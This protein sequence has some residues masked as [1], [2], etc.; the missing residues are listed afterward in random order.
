MKNTIVDGL[1]SKFIKD[2]VINLEDSGT[3]KLKKWFVEIDHF[4]YIDKRFQDRLI[5]WRN[6][7]YSDMSDYRVNGT[8]PESI[9]NS[10]MCNFNNYHEQIYRESYFSNLS[11]A[12]YINIIDLLINYLYNIIRENKVELII[13]QEAPHGAYSKILYDIAKAM[14][15]RTLILFSCFGI[16]KTAYCW[17]LDDIGYF[18]LNSHIGCSDKIPLKMSSEKNHDYC[19]NVKVKKY[20][21]ILDYIYRHI[22]KDVSNYFYKQNAI[23]YRKKYFK[24]NF[25]KSLKYVYFPLHL[26]PEM[27]TATLGGIYSNQLLAIERLSKIIPEEWVIYVKEHPWQKDY[28]W[29]GKYFY[30]RLSRISKVRCINKNISSEEMINNAQFVSTVTGTAGYEAI[31]KG[32]PALVFGKVWYRDLPGVSIY[33]DDLKNTDIIKHFSITDLEFSMKK[34]S[35]NF[36][37]GIVNGDFLKHCNG[38]NRMQNICLVSGFLKEVI[39]KET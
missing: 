20:D 10:L 22:L 3:I 28:R 29:R 4:D 36:L 8:C 16:N 5:H 14:N 12:D 7:L 23:K 19:R 2:V 34:L 35:K 6:V 32:V 15:I 21:G 17:D 25:D 39:I 33:N 27:T 30:E 38:F 26:Q 31:C 13:F 18:K 11:N 1:S 9:Y 37:P 24:Y